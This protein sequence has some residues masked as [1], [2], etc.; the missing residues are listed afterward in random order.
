MKIADMFPSEYLRGID[1]STPMA[2]TIG[3]VSP[4]QVKSRDTGKPET[5]FVVRFKETP[6]KLRLTLTKAKA[7]AAAVNDQSLDSDNWIGKKITVFGRWEKHFGENHFVVNVRSVQRGDNTPQQ[8]GKQSNKQPNQPKQRDQLGPDVL[9]ETIQKKAAK[10]GMVDSETGEMWPIA[11][12]PFGDDAAKLVA[13]KFTEA[14]KGQEAAKD[15]Y[16]ASL[17]WL[18]GCNSATKLTAATADALLDWLLNGNKQAKMKAA[19]VAPAQD[20]ALAVYGVC[21]QDADEYEQ[22][23][24]DDVFGPAQQTGYEEN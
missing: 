8:P 23:N 12:H 22:P 15:M 18:T 17:E 7:M 1:V 14:F 13:A 19:V 6:K 20:E 21:H 2:L 9:K 5:E 4:E 11:Q 10:A 3:S 16:H 24:L